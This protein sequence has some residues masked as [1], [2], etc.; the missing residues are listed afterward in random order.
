MLATQ[1]TPGPWEVDKTV[2]GE[3]GIFTKHGPRIAGI[4]ESNRHPPTEVEA[5]ARL[6]AA[7]PDLLAACEA[8]DRIELIRDE[9]SENC[10]R[11]NGAGRTT[12]S[13]EIIHA[14]KRVKELRAE[15]RDIREQLRA[16][17]AKATVQQVP[18]GA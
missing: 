16:A 12:P 8:A 9:I 14:S 5:N 4:D 3:L 2:I 17:I 15:L 13:G 1:H 6:I 18:A 7:A 11:I 10:A